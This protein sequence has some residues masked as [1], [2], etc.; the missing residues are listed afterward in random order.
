MRS[1]VKYN[2]L[3]KEYEMGRESGTHKGEDEFK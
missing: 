1:V 2:Y 3:G